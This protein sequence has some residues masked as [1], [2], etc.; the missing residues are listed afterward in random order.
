MQVSSELWIHEEHPSCSL[1]AGWS[2]V[3]SFFGFK[4]YFSHFIWE[5]IWK[6]S[7]KLPW[8][9]FLRK[10]WKNIKKLYGWCNGQIY[11]CVYEN[12]HEALRVSLPGKTWQILIYSDKSLFSGCC[13]AS[14]CYWNLETKECI[15]GS[16]YLQCGHLSKTLNMMTSVTVIILLSQHKTMNLQWLMTDT[17]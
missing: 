17:S 9:D 11:K 5:T 16:Q 3:C 14:V 15:D 8:D 7:F 6:K 1:G 4:T 13:F 2:L 12:S 10:L